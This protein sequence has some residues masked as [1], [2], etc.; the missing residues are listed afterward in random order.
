MVNT[1]SVLGE[2]ALTLIHTAMLLQMCNFP[3]CPQST[4]HFNVLFP[5]LQ[6]EKGKLFWQKASLLLIHS[7]DPP[8]AHDTLFSSEAFCFFPSLLVSSP[9]FWNFLV[10]G[11][12]LTQHGPVSQGKSGLPLLGRRCLRGGSGAPAN[13]PILLGA[14]ALLPDYE[15]FLGEQNEL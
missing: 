11:Q 9:A 3:N 1:T 5:L 14:I 15:L 4:K 2:K 8:P 6:R 12:V 10:Q 7:G 13:S